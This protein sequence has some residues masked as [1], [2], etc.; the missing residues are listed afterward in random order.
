M[1]NRLLLLFVIALSIGLGT[2]MYGQTNDYF[3]QYP[4]GFTESS[5]EI[6]IS[7]LENPISLSWKIE[8]TESEALRVTTTNEVIA[9]RADLELGVLNG[10]AQAQLIIQD[11][12]VRALLENRS[13][14][15]PNTVFV[16]PGGARFSTAAEETIKGVDVLCG[17]LESD[18]EPDDR[19]ILAISAEPTLPFPPLIQLD[20]LSAAKGLD[21]PL[22]H[23]SSVQPF[24]VDF[25]SQFAS[26]FRLEL[27][28][29]Q[30]IEQQE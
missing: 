7:E 12:S 19:T 16:V 28:E 1:K 5:Y 24:L 29:F 17:V 30:R 11:E 18:D 2:M 22:Q 6:R 4:G 9:N 15:I 14:L 27:T 8:A 25:G 23:C 26:T 21:A 3:L 20:E 10:I 13:S